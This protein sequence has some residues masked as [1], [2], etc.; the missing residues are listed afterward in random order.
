[1]QGELR[2][3][4]SVNWG[5]PKVPPFPEMPTMMGQLRGTKPGSQVLKTKSG[6][7][8]CMARQG[9][10]AAQVKQGPRLRLELNLAPKLE[11]EAPSKDSCSSLS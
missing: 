7:A 3:S 8:E 1:M 6:S 11:G 2:G 9:I 5:Q 10:P 4:A